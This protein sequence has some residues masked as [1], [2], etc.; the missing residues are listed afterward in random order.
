MRRWH[1]SAVTSSAG[2]VLE[3]AQ[4]WG[5]GLAAFAGLRRGKSDAFARH[6][7]ISYELLQQGFAKIHERDE[8]F[9]LHAS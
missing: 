3:Q 5:E 1:W 2:I 9:N 8:G 6:V 7:S 4:L